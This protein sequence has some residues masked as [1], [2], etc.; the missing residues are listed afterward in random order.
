MTGPVPALFEPAK[1]RLVRQS[2]GIATAGNTYGGPRGVWLECRAPG[3]NESQRIAGGGVFHF[4]DAEAEAIFRHYGWIGIGQRMM[5]AR[6]PECAKNEAIIATFRW[7]T[8]G[9][10]N[11]ARI[12]ICETDVAGRL[13]WCRKAMM[14]QELADM[15]KPVPVINALLREVQARLLAAVKEENNVE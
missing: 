4:S 14:L 8:E 12:V 9:L 5:D 11:D 7:R 1:Y 6:C 13:L 3:C 10:D 15:Q 2:Y